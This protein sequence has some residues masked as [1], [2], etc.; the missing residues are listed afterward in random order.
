MTKE[1]YMKMTEYLR[2]EPRRAQQVKRVNSI[3]TGIVYLIYPAYLLALFLKKDEFLM[4]AVLVP[5]ISFVAVSLFR[6]RYNAPLPYEKFG[7]APVI[8]KETKGKSFPSRHVFS[9][10]VIA[11]TVFY[12]YHGAGV[13]L[14]VVGV[15]LAVIRVL[16]GVHEPKDVVVGAL[17]GI[18][19]GVA[20]YYIL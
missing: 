18:L 10:F 8:E 6:K 16:G 3:L 7:I 2:K 4:R 1:S 20:G 15:L 5:G 11:V 9:V 17:V 14:C 12:R 13:F 19:S